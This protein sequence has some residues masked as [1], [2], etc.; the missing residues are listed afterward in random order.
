MKTMIHSQDPP[1]HLWDEA[2]STILYVQNIL[3]H[4]A[5]RFKTPEEMYTRKKLEVSRIKIFDCPVYVHIQEE[6][7]TKLD[8]SGKKEY[9]LDNVISK[10]VGM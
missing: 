1:M 7:R 6:K 3:S 4:S 10:L 2:T 8:P 9:L 5:I